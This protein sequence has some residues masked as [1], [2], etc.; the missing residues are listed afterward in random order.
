MT[1]TGKLRIGLDITP[2]RPPLTGIGNYELH[3]LSAVLSHADA[4]DFVG[5]DR[6]RWKDVDPAY[7]GLIGLRTSS[8]NLPH[9]VRQRR[10]FPAKPI[11]VAY[12]SLRR[13]IFEATQRSR[14]L[15]AFHAF[16]Y[17]APGRIDAPVIP[18]V[19]DVSFVRFPELH[20]ADRLRRL[21]GLERQL[22]SAPA[23]HTIS[24]FS[25]NEIADVFG[26]EPSRIFVIHPAV[27]P[28]L[29]RSES[30]PAETLHKYTLESDRYF[31]V[32]STLEP[33]KNLRTLVAAYSRLPRSQRDRFPL[34]VVGA[35]GWGDLDLPSE[36]T[37][38]QRDGS[39]RFLGF[40]SNGDLR[41]LY[42]HTRAMFY[43][44][45]YEGFGIP[46]I[47][48]LAC[49]TRVV[50]SDAPSLT[51]AAGEVTTRVPALGVDGWLNQLQAAIDQRGVDN[52]AIDSRKAHALHFSWSASAERTLGLY[53]KVAAQ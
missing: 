51:E 22:R 20:P 7:L 40:V 28:D 25:A 53:R 46:I 23:V 24:Q 9:L 6:F 44:S 34:C 17:L 12:M 45:I 48:A 18:V 15:T 41:A 27:N 26:I 33:R 5:F 30:P 10:F 2:L 35:S 36:W 43:P 14:S 52:A 21:E 42:E 32:V 49:G 39:L 38:L 16:A 3:L 4:P 37:T 50:C 47:D 13:A 1:G 19:Y 11:G 31:L 29:L 8:L